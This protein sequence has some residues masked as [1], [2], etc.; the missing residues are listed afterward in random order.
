MTI[1]NKYRP[2]DLKTETLHQQLSQGVVMEGLNATRKCAEMITQVLP[3]DQVLALSGDLGSG[4]STF[5][6]FLGETLG[7]TQPIKSPTYNFYNVYQGKRQL[8]HCDAYRLKDSAAMDDLLIED[9]LKSPWLL[10]IEWPE[11]I[12]TW[13]PHQTL[14]LRFDIQ[15]PGIHTLHKI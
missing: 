7:V 15:S 4:K 6:S 13:L 8:V 12:R 5:V 3:E 9:F 11:N 14:W 1:N 2:E 10:C